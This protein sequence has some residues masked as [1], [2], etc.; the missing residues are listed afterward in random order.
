MQNLGA[1][2]SY[3]DSY[4]TDYTHPCELSNSSNGRLGQSPQSLFDWEVYP[5]PAHKEVVLRYHSSKYPKLQLKIH[6]TMG[7]LVHEQAVYHSLNHLIELEHLQA[8]MYLCSLVD[9]NGNKIGSKLLN[10]SR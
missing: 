2:S 9:K 5:N 3:Y 4:W 7:Q 8:G 6:N 1:F 10:K